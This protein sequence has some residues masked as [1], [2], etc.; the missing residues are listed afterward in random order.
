MASHTVSFKE[1]I[2]SVNSVVVEKPVE[3]VVTDLTCCFT[4]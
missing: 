2:L 1:M 4:G 3:V